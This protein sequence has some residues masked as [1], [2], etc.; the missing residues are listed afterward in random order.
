MKIIIRILKLLVL[1]VIVIMIIV[2]VCIYIFAG[3]A[4][5]FAVEKGATD[6]L[7]VLVR[8]ED[9]ELSILRGN[10]TIRGLS[11]NNPHGYNYEHLLR[12]NATSVTASV[13]SLRDDPARIKQI[14]LDGIDLV[15]EQRG[16]SNNLKDIMDAL[17]KKPKPKEEPSGKK[18]R[19]DELKITNATVK[20]KLLPVPGKADT[21]TL[22]LE[23]IV[24]KDLGYDDKLNTG[25]LAAKIMTA[26]TEQIATEGVDILPADI[27]NAARS[28][29]DMAVDIGKTA[30][31]KGK[32][33]LDSGKDLG[34]G[35]FDNVTNIL[36]PKE[37][38]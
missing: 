19:I 3:R 9:V 32:E 20:V 23:P 21:I 6:T 30:T 36:K 8:V 16:L 2:G 27:V 33:I 13:A 11:V 31:E 22:N 34:K 38:Q 15:I 1:L 25:Q 37:K 18:L 29:L 4:V 28:T 26:I 12:M 5:K 7:G 35:I 24:M 14:E 10:V 17:K